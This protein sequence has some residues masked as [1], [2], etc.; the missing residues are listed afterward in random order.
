MNKEL[1]KIQDNNVY[2]IDHVTN[3]IYKSNDTSSRAF[4]IS[5]K[6]FDC[7]IKGLLLQGYKF[8]DEYIGINKYTLMINND[9]KNLILNNNI[10]E[11]SRECSEAFGKKICIN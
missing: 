3:L 7:I 10:N 11:I 6:T 4:P 5:S 2:Y 8:I 9:I 1:Y